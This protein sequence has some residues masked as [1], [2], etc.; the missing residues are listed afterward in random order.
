MLLGTLLIL[1]I[2][3]FMN[4]T[5][6]INNKFIIFLISTLITLFF[7]TLIYFNNNK[8]RHKIAF[9]FYTIM[10]L[11]MFAD[12]MYYSYFNSLPS[13]KMLKLMNQVATVGDSV[14]SLLS[15]KNLLFLLDIP[16]LIIYFKKKKEKM[17]EEFKEYDR[18]T[19][20]GLPL[21]IGLFLAFALAILG[22][23]D[24]MTPVTNQEIYTYHIKDIK[25]AL[26][27][28]DIAEGVGIFTQEDLEELKDRTN[29]KDSKYTGIGKGKNL[30]VIQV[31]ALQNFPINRFYDG[32]EITPNL[33]KF[34][35]EKGSLY[36]DNY[37]QQI[38]RGNTSDAEF[39][40]NNSLYPSMEDPTYTQYEQNTFYGLPWIL[41]DNG[42]TSW[43][44][45]GYE[46]EFW[47]R[48][49]AYPN[50]G[51][52]RFISEED[53][54]ITEPI[55]FGISDEEFFEQSLEYLKEMDNPFHAFLITLTS[56]TPFKMP[57]E[58]KHLNIREEHE[59]TILG[60][61]LQ[62]I[63][64]TDKALGQFFEDLKK[65]GLYDDTVIALYGDHFAI[66]GLNDSGVELMT[67]FLGHPYDIDEM[68]KI[69][70]IIH[71]PGE[72]INETISN[73]GSQLDF[74]PTILNI[75]GYKNEKGLMFGRD[76]VNY[77][78]EN[79]VASQTYVLK[80]SFIDKDTIFC[81]SRD[82]VFDNSKAKDKKTKKSVDITPLKKR[83]EYVINEINKSDFILKKNL[84]NT[85]IENQGNIDLSE[86]GDLNIP[87]D[88]YIGSCY[89]NSL[90]ELN[91]YYDKGYRL[92][93]VDLQWTKDEE[94]VL[95]KDWYWFYNNLFENP[96]E[97]HP[98]KEEFKNLKMADANQQMTASD[99][100]KW[101]MKHK[102]AYIVLRT[103]EKDKSIFLKIKDD[104][105]NLRD[106]F[107][108]EIDDFEDYLSVSNKAFKNILL[109]LSQNKYTEGIIMDFLDRNDIFGV[110]M[111]EELSTTSLSKKLKK[112]GIKTYVEGIDTNV[113]KKALE[114]KV[115]GFF[116]TPDCQI[117]VELDLVPPL[118]QEAN[119]E[120]KIDNRHLVAHAGGEIGGLTYTN[121]RE[122]L[123]LSY[124]NGIRLMEVDFHWTTDDKLVCVHS[125]DG[126]INRHFNVEA[127]RYSYDQF[128]S[129]NMINGWHQLTPH[130][131]RLWMER[132]PDAYI[133][134]DIKENN[135]KGLEI[136]SEKYP[137][138]MD[139]II[140]QIY[141]MDEYEKVKSLGYE[142]IILTLYMIRNTDDEIVQ[143]AQNNKLFAVTMPEEKAYTDLPKRLKDIGV[144]VY[145]HTINEEGTVKKLKENCVSGFY[146]DRLTPLKPQ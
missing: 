59:D 4:I 137:H 22:I 109:N 44:F 95:L 138:I 61:Y 104:Y 54:E 40:T 7:F 42:Y 74:L 132:H 145:A 108:V 71:V 130:T 52:Q 82:G 39:V 77:E 81:M 129:F 41:R 33:N 63:H 100:I 69:P 133:I 83:Y 79:H 140:P 27:E 96:I 35:K 32:Q 92:L 97:G 127:K 93:S 34:I 1:K 14:A 98:T 65:E 90:E 112:M 11:I 135:I 76:L 128:I 119:I 114:K 10:S 94:I 64:Y 20:V 58:Y 55:G 15:F 57:E 8:K 48:N 72:E 53:Y 75:M 37:Y 38:G 5:G 124:E 102:D 120:N 26:I 19:R 18:Y 126:F 89:Y 115:H 16:L 121:A 105:P 13:I 91:D 122:A 87:N 47:N 141:S 62:S 66:T 131:L 134:T 60:D 101:M 86:L 146:T 31:E 9:V 111:D 3:L 68:F 118:P 21:G 70:L 80:G 73:I 113:K 88:K 125:W 136:L 51:F 6:I 110:I 36:F 143:F 46:K 116:I 50:Q 12:V 30:M 84:L 106:R 17:I 103:T 28:E 23:Q 144:Y 67:D 107:I 49:K 139:R 85:F 29:L 99:L 78:G 43:V 45:H 142:N 2:L 123:D 24:L 25:A 56:H 117:Q